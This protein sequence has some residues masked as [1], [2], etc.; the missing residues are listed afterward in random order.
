VIQSG[1]APSAKLGEEARHVGRQCLQLSQEAF[2]FAEKL[3]LKVLENILSRYFA[4]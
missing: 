2:A 1:P 4:G 3:K